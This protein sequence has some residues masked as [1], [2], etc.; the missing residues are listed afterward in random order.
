MFPA[1]S[2]SSFS[3]NPGSDSH[4]N[5]II[6]SPGTNIPGSSAIIMGR[7]QQV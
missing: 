3:V 4:K 1:I 5:V 7:F 6:P 2:T